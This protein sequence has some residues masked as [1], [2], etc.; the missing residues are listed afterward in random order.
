M[1]H[2]FTE[3]AEKAVERYGY[4]L[5]ILRSQ[6]EIVGRR[7]GIG[8]DDGR[9]EAV[10]VSQGA[11]RT[12]LS[13]EQGL[14]NDD[15]AEVARRAYSAAL[16][17]LGLPDAV[18]EDRFAE[19]IFSAAQ[20]TTRIIAAQAERDVMTMAQHIQSTAMRIDL[21]VRS[22]R[23]SRGSAAAQVFLEDR[24]APAFKFL[25]RM[26]RRFKA[27]KHIR[28]IYRQH[29]LNVYNE[30]YM[31]VVATH[32]WETV[33]VQHPDPNYKWQ[34][35]ELAIVS[36]ED[37]FPLYYDVRAEIFHPSSEA[38]LTIKHPGSD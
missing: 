31:D 19:F 1:N 22:G 38:T 13:T 6:A 14:I 24:A 26:G 10:S 2:H 17:D 34:G 20:Y 27:T 16:S 32:G 36:G 11:A 9:E 37:D 33:R 5:N 30:V 23:H 4:L 25:D 15:T 28:D 29:L 35:A 18:I 3:R 21:Y 12:F 8:M 7:G